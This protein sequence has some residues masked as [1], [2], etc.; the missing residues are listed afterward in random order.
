M[1]TAWL[2]K[3]SLIGLLIL[4]RKSFLCGLITVVPPAICKKSNNVY[5]MWILLIMKYWLMV[6]MNNINTC[7]NHTVWY[8]SIRIP[9][10]WPLQCTSLT[11]VW[12]GRYR[13][14][15]Q[16]HS[17]IF[18]KHYLIVTENVHVALTVKYIDIDL[19]VSILSVECSIHNL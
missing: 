2:T 9:D 18:V 6:I 5:T 10:K 7:G 16:I 3:L 11:Q 14:G 4:L 17:I 13:W 8:V 12:A 15:S 1:V 19:D